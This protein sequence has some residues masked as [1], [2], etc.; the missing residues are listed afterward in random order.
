MESL[1]AFC[2]WLGDTD[3]SV[4]IQAVTWIIPTVQTIHILAI[5]VVMS[6]VAMVDLRLLGL[7]G[8]SEPVAAVAARFLPWIWCALPVLL[9]TGSIL[10]IGE[11]ARSLENPA[12][13]AK[14]ALLIVAMI[15]TFL[16]QRPMGREIAYWELTANRRNAARA[17]A[18]LS[19][20][21]WVSIV[22]AGRW[23]AYM[24]TA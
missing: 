5:A 12:F 11:P 17:I 14:M 4:G 13:Q 16:F 9:V 15:A 10:V 2:E 20:S 18:V 6:S 1:H 3:L 7:V 21:L 23:I 8:R 24:Q 19:L 22:F